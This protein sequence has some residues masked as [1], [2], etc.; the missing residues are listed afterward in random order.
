MKKATVI[1]LTSA[2]DFLKNAELEK[3]YVELEKS[4]GDD[5]ENADVEYALKAVEYWLPKLETAKKAATPL[6]RGEYMISHWKS[7]LE[8]IA[9]QGE[10]RDTII[11]ALK[12]AVFLLA[13]KFYSK[14]F[15]Q[16]KELKEAEPYRKVGLC[17]KILGEYD[18]A[19]EFLKFACEL[20]KNSSAIMAELADCYACYGETKLSKVFF[21]EAF[22]IDPSGIELQF[23]ESALILKL[24]ERVKALGIKPEHISEWIPIY[25]MLDGVFNVK[26]ELKSVEFGQLKQKIFLLEYEVKDGSGE[27]LDSLVPRLIN[28]YFW[29]IDHYIAVHEDKS[30]IDGIL[31]RIR[32]LD[33]NIYDCYTR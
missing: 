31:L 19:L 28:Y 32:V 3:A 18:R 9:K 8:F 6:E 23:L 13:L 11:Y 12:R 21:R 22:F 25:G 14:L 4:L 30:K 33:K 16:E 15:E 1:K 2:L 27:Q 20:D 26:R 10:C 17:Y 24:I 5:L 7:F 29:L